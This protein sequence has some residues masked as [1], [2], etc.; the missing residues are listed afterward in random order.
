MSSEQEQE[1]EQEQEPGPRL[2]LSAAVEDC[3]LRFRELWEPN[4]NIVDNR[5]IALNKQNQKNLLKTCWIDSDPG[6][7]EMPEEHR[8]DLS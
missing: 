5:W 2:P 7:S 1:Q 3:W 6:G 4:E 8:P